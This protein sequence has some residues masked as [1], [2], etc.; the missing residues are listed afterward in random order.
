MKYQEIFRQALDQIKSK[1]EL[2]KS[3]FLAGGSISNVV[4]N[5]I[6]NKNAPV[7]DLD[8][9]HLK[10]VKKDFT[11]KDLKS[12]QHFIRSEKW[13][14]EDYTGLNIGYQQKGYY[15]I[16]KVTVDGI[17]NNIEYF[18]TTD[19][20]SLVLDSFDINCCQLG[21]DIEKD[22]FVW[23]KNFETFLKTGELRLC[24][25]S[26]PP[27]SAMRLVKKKYDLEASLP[28]IELD[29]IATI[30][31]TR[32]FIDSSKFRFKDRYAKMFKKYQSDLKS[33]FKLVREKDLEIYLLTN[34]GVSDYIWSLESKLS[35]DEYKK[36]D[37]SGLHLSKD[38]LYYMRNILHKKE[39]EKAWHK[40][41]PIIDSSLTFNE[42]FD[43]SPDKVDI[44][45]LSKLVNHAP[46]SSRNL[47]GKSLS[48]QIEIFD[49]IILKFQKDPL[50]GI[51]ILENYDLESHDLN[52]EMEL[53]LMELAIR[54]D[55]LEDPRDKVYH[56]LGIETWDRKKD[57]EFYPI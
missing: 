14:Y 45:K 26:S 31:G 52:D 41:H 17:Y 18:A 7:N 10:G 30:M 53:L 13:V 36:D 6:S 27:H 8:I 35:S 32:C 28:E 4:W 39:Y 46:N 37:I 23:T 11:N 9:Y 42:Y 20:K 29:L 49:M 34:Y 25:L 19:D 43:V 33:R 2:P 1:W 38:Y 24:N 57:D 40:L 48:K 5:I 3:G 22:E 50:I 56:I 55:L 54:K 12:K 51:K 21:Y 16:E 44:E 15:T 47:R